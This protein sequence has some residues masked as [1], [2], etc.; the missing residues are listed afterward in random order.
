MW[1][2]IFINVK[3]I[4]LKYSLCLI[5]SYLFSVV[6]KRNG[7]YFTYLIIWLTEQHYLN[8]FLYLFSSFALCLLH[9]LFKIMV[10]DDL[11]SEAVFIW[12]STREYHSHKM[13]ENFYTKRIMLERYEWNLCQLWH[14]VNIVSSPNTVPT[15]WIQFTIIIIFSKFFMLYNLEII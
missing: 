10:S 15:F 1:I 4:L 9:I 13:S 3:W 6:I 11:L 14:I 8:G 7:L 2:F 12:G 5:V